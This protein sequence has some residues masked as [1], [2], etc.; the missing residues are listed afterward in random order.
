MANCSL[1]VH[2][3]SNV[4]C[5]RRLPIVYVSGMYSARS[6]VHREIRNSV[7][8]GM[9][10]ELPKR[11]AN[12]LCTIRIAVRTMSKDA[13]ACGQVREKTRPIMD[14]SPTQVP[15]ESSRLM[16]NSSCVTVSLGAVG[17][18]MKWPHTEWNTRIRRN[19]LDANL[20]HSTRHPLLCTVKIKGNA[21]IRCSK[22][23]LHSSKHLSG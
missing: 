16:C 12:S 2:R 22:L 20:S 10:M 9:K 13:C 8:E 23:V 15:L 3:R 21:F 18:R 1:L 4:F 19:T 5:S 11:A 17:G 14:M 6:G 7:K